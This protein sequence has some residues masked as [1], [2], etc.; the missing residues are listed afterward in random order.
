MTTR[1]RSWAGASRGKG[2]Q[3]APVPA[4]RRSAR[5]HPGAA[6]GGDGS[7]ADHRPRRRLCAAAG[8]RGPRAGV[9][10]GTRCAAAMVG[11]GAPRRPQR[12]G[13][14]PHAAPGQ[15]QA[16]A[17]RRRGVPGRAE[18]AGRRRTR[19]GERA[20]PL[21]CTPGAGGGRAGDPG[22]PSRRGPA[23]P[24]VLRRRGGAARRVGAP[25]PTVRVGTDPHLGDLHVHPRG[26]R[27]AGG[28]T[29]RGRIRPGRAARGP[30]SR[31]A[32]GEPGTAGRL[33]LQDD[34]GR[35]GPRHSDSRPR[36]GPRRAVAA[37]CRQDR[38][39]A[40]RDGAGER[41]PGARHDRSL[42]GRGGGA[43]RR[44][45]VA[46]VP[47]EHARPGTRLGRRG[48]AGHGRG[49]ASRLPIG[50]GAAGVRSG[51]GR[52]AARGH[53]RRRPRGRPGPR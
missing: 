43:D 2:A 1:S 52:R 32:P 40:A 42:A 44:R 51:P 28:R 4:I 21:G 7:R 5:A 36:A 19:R 18:R 26:P 31:P 38:R 50:G 39:R 9:G 17:T 45:V 8:G 15:R 25:A 34:R 47:A 22:R 41:R 3:Q 33:R 6:A 29:A 10:G 49:R 37:R 35:H 13:R 14:R 30:G 23:R 46:A 27:W 12:P 53:P 24:A 11:P 16:G 48:P 20:R